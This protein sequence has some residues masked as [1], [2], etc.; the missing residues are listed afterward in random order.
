MVH[1]MKI[2]DFAYKAIKN[3]EKDIEVRLNEEKRQIIK[4]GDIIEFEHI[5]T[6]KILKVEVI[7]LYRF[8]T[9]KDLFKTFNYKRLGIK[10]TDTSN[11]MYNFYTKD[12]ENKYGALGIEIKLI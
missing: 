1:R 12:D 10:K 7:N 2:V 8:G 11:I 5:Y 6:K 9:F 3:Q 4:I